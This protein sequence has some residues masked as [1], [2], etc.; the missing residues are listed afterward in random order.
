MKY[1]FRFSFYETLSHMYKT[2][3]LCEWV[4]VFARKEVILLFFKI[5]YRLINQTL[6]CHGLIIGKFTINNRNSPPVSIVLENFWGHMQYHA[7]RDYFK[8]IAYD[9][10]TSFFHIHGNCHICSLWV[11][12]RNNKHVKSIFFCNNMD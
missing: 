11:Y 6:F 5:W 12:S 2:R 8:H 1:F 3:I 4:Y 9:S 7:D 10:S